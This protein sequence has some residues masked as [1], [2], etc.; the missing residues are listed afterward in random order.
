MSVR[1][2]I[3]DGTKMCGSEHVGNAFIYSVYFIPS[4]VFTE[5]CFSRIPSSK[6]AR[7]QNKSSS[8]VEHFNMCKRLVIAPGAH[9]FEK[10]SGLKK[11]FFT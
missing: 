11:I 7:F 8:S 1:N 6:Q 5:G 9:C 3:T 4:L 10:L 2:E